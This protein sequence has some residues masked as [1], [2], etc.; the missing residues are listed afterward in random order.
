MYICH[1]CGISIRGNKYDSIVFEFN[2]TKRYYGCV[3]CDRFGIYIKNKPDLKFTKVKELIVLA[4]K[5]GLRKEEFNI[6]DKDKIEL[7]T[8]REEIIDEE[9]IIREERK[10]VSQKE[11][12][13]FLKEFILSNGHTKH[14]SNKQII[15]FDHDKLEYHSRCNRINSKNIVMLEQLKDYFN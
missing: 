2:K 3:Y 1:K 7:I 6:I 8:F 15:G 13:I 9:I 12:K 5:L 4:K 11:F 14:L 10:F